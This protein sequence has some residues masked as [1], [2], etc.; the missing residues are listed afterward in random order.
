[1][2]LLKMSDSLFCNLRELPSFLWVHIGIWDNCDIQYFGYQIRRRVSDADG[3]PTVT[4][5]CVPQACLTPPPVEM[6]ILLSTFQRNPSS[7]LE[8]L[9][10]HLAHCI[11]FQPPLP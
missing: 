2:T 10:G 6:D 11:V 9:T 1:M 8:W 5:A 4:L 7:W 3:V